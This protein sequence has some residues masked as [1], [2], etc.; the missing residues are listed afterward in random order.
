MARHWL[1][2]RLLLWQLTPRPCSTHQDLLRKTMVVFTWMRSNSMMK[3]A[4][5]DWCFKNF[6]DYVN[7]L[8]ILHEPAR[9]CISSFIMHTILIMKILFHLL[10][11]LCSP[12]SRKEWFKRLIL[13][14]YV[15]FVQ[16]PTLSLCLP[17]GIFSRFFFCPINQE[18]GVMIITIYLFTP[19]THHLSYDCMFMKI[20]GLL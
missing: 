1:R 13:S 19:L 20:T 2:T 12:F 17:W 18:K 15:S 5:S 6:G 8:F 9:L 10:V 7:L 3:S 16:Q 11:Q 4:R 14:V